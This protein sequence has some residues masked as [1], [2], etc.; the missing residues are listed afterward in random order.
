VV[1]A[2]LVVLIQIPA[3]S[4]G[5]AT[6]PLVVSAGKESPEKASTLVKQS[7]RYI[8][9][10]YAP[11]VLFLFLL[12]DSLIKAVFSEKYLPSAG[13]LRIYLPFLFCFA[14]SGFV[15]LA[16]DYCGKARLRMVF[17]SIS[18]VINVALNLWLI[19]KFG[20][21]GAAWT[22]QVTY[23][24]LVMIY[25]YLIKNHYKIS[26]KGVP[27]FL[28]KLSCALVL[29]AVLLIALSNILP[30][31]RAMLMATVCLAL[32]GYALALFFTKLVGLDE[33]KSILSTLSCP[34]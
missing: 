8:V 33:I 1:A 32:V 24:P 34:R 11:V 9:I 22:T 28:A 21:V 3:L 26:L 19:P 18:A 13:V 20:M 6:A 27:V 30:E 7:L 2:Q 29:S 31:S 15:S 25:L 10:F 17:V 12:S 5:N 4:F 16:L 14:L 23:V